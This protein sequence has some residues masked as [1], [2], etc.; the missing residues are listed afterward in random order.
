MQ[1]IPQPLLSFMT[2]CIALMNRL[3][4]DLL[5][6]KSKVASFFL[7]RLLEASR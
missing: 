4:R 6:G 3:V 1:I 2:S 7:A 5:A